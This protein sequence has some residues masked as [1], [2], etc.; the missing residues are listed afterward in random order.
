[1]SRLATLARAL[2]ARWPTPAI[3]ALAQAFAEELVLA[4]QGETRGP[5]V[6]LQVNSLVGVDCR[7]TG[8]VD[9]DLGDQP[10]GRWVS[11]RHARLFIHEGLW[12]VEDLGSRNGTWLNGRR[13]ERARVLAPGARL[14]FANVCFEVVLVNPEARR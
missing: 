3:A 1:M 6:R 7:A 12:L 5:R 14:C 8:P 4:P 11:G 13:I 10:G 9:L 2:A